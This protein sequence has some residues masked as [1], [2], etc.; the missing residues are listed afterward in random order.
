MTP[1][2]LPVFL[3]RLKSR[4]GLL[5]LSSTARGFFHPEME[6]SGLLDLLLPKAQGA[7]R[8]VFAG[9]I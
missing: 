1:A 8:C 7:Y 5:E 9:L 3:F 2:A 4:H 6:K